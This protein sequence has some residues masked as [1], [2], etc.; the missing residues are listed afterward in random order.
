LGRFSLS[1]PL[2][3]GSMEGMK[4]ILLLL[5]LLVS[6]QCAAQTQDRLPEP[7]QNPSATFRLFRTKNVY[8]LLKLDTR[9]GQIWQVQWGSEPKQMF[10]GTVNKT[11]LLPADPTHPTV[12]EP[13]RFTLEPTDNIFTFVLIDQDDGRTWR[14]QWGDNPFIMPIP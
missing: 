9:T 5:C 12:L 11:M 2:C 7:S 6:F 8:M 4:K 13:G 1:R 14:V 10:T 3:R